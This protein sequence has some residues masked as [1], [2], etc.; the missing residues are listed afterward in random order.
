LSVSDNRAYQ[1]NMALREAGKLAD[2]AALFRAAIAPFGFDTFACG[3]LDMSDRER[4]VFYI[5]DWS[6]S[7]RA[8]YMGSGLINR[9]PI[10]A[11]LTHRRA[12]YSW[13][14][15]RAER[16]LARAGSEALDL[17]AAAGWT[18]G[19][20]VPLRSSGNRVGLVS[21]A[22][23]RLIDDPETRAYLCLIAV[24]LHAHARSLVP[25]EGFAIPP[26]GLTPR[27]IEALRLVAR[28]MADADIARALGIA[29]STAHEFVEKAKHRLKTR[30]RA[31]MIA[32][33]VAFGIIDI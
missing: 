4:A 28:G 13:S 31:E 14:D 2:C 26:M 1:F 27:E 15:L 29:R 3:E 10:V 25:R 21:L 7:W 5:I 19:L 33:A 18:E 6:E 24:C 9:D 11:E 30:S 22:G 32:V 20:V 8:F 17:A 16:K 23:D 12:P